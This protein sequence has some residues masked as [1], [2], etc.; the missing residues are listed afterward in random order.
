[1]PYQ[2]ALAQNKQNL[3]QPV[4]ELGF[5]IP[6]SAVLFI[7]ISQHSPL[8]RHGTSPIT[9]SGTTYTISQA[10]EPSLGQYIL[11]ESASLQSGFE[12]SLLRLVANK[13]K[14]TPFTLLFYPAFVTAAQKK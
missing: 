6:F 1:M 4:L 7:L 9:Q 14:R 10:T 13:G 5:M 12:L 8:V 11:S 2:K 3:P